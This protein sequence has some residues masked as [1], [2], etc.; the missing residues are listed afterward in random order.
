M[1]PVTL[2]EIQSNFF[3]GTPSETKPEMRVLGDSMSSQV[4]NEY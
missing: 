2:S 1:A 3:L 4:D